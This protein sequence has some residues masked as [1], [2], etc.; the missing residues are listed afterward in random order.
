MEL[1]T[2]GGQLERL[3]LMVTGRRRAVI[4]RR[5]NIAPGRV[6]LMSQAKGVGVGGVEGCLYQTEKLWLVRVTWGLLERGWLW[7]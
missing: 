1:I 5:A 4:M 3:G 7:Q 6:L 2:T